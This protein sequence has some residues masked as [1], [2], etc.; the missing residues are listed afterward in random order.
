MSL[1]KFTSQAVAQPYLN[2]RFQS[3][4]VDGAISSSKP[5][6]CANAHGIAG[7]WNGSPLAPVALSSSYATISSGANGGAPLGNYGMPQVATG[8]QY[9]TID[10]PYFQAWA[11]V[12]F[13]TNNNTASV[14]FSVSDG[15]SYDASKFGMSV[16]AS[17]GVLTNI[18]FPVQL[19]VSV[20][21]G[22]FSIG[23]RTADVGLTITVVAWTLM[24]SQLNGVPVLM[25]P[26]P[27]PQLARDA[28]QELKDEEPVALPRLAA[29][30]RPDQV[31]SEQAP[32][33]IAAQ[34]IFRAPRSKKQ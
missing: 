19:Q 5:S 15:V 10:S 18:T 4:A 34:A 29:P 33:H 17:A 3:L 16:P 27:E 20:A 9:S 31:P 24:A 22:T 32:G 30:M 28:K 26:A 8:L 14:Q 21:N 13:K 23:A 7:L 1:N 25:G 6:F 12:S 2:P 11:S